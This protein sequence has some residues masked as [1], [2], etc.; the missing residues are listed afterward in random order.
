[1]RRTNALTLIASAAGSAFALGSRPTAAAEAPIRIGSGLADSYGTP[2]YGV[3][4]GRFQQ[5]GLNVTLTTL[6]N[7]A[8][9]VQAVAGN[10]LDV[11]LGDPIQVA[12]AI[13]AG[14]PMAIFAGCGLYS[15]DAPTTLLCTKPESTLRKAP[16]LDGKTVAVVSLASISSLAVTEWLRQ[17]GADLSTVKIIEMPFS[18]MAPALQRDRVDAAFIAEPYLSA[19]RSSLR[20]MAKAFDAIAPSFYISAWF[21]PRS[22][23]AANSAAAKQLTKAAY[24]VARWANSDRAATAAILAKETK[25]PLARVQAMTRVKFATD[26]RST[27][28]QPLL[29]IAFRYK[30]LTK[31]VVAADIMLSPSTT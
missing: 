12:N 11:G 16:E 18:A 2:Y 10:A 25:L 4:S 21:A 27:D 17:N 7:G 9:I 20:V 26:L 23:L 15:T 13:N 3:D 19:D 6:A 28:I 31:P 8:A 29:D 24:D 1:M 14:V 30:K 22:W 5:E